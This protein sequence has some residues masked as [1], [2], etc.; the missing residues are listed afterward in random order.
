[1]THLHVLDGGLG[2]SVQDRGR[3]G[4]RALGV[5]VSGALDPLL[6]AAANALAG[7]PAD[8]AALEILLHG[9]RLQ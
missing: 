3:V 6:L 1:M 2:V 7:A 5:P 4:Y 9:P 8:A